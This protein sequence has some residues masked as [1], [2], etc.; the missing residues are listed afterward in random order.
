MNPDAHDKHIERYIERYEEENGITLA[1]PKFVLG[2]SVAILTGETVDAI[3][4]INSIRRI[5]E[6]SV[7][8]GVAVDGYEDL[9][10]EEDELDVIFEDKYAEIVAGKQD[11]LTKLRYRNMELEGA[12]AGTTEALNTANYEMYLLRMEISRMKELAK[13]AISDIENGLS[14]VFTLN[15]LDK[16]IDNG[17]PTSPAPKKSVPKRARIRWSERGFSSGSYEVLGHSQEKKAYVLNISTD[18]NRVMLK[19]VKMTDCEAVS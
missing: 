6:E 13:K 17:L 15:S 3:G 14:S 12:L 11:E 5:E 4:T 19:W 8:Y 2:Q 9:P 7:T 1:I 16:I 10:F 18:D